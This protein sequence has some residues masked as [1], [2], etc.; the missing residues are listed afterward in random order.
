MQGVVIHIHTGVKGR[1]IQGVPKKSI[2]TP[3]IVELLDCHQTT[4][5]LFC[6]IVLF[7]ILQSQ[8][9]IWI[10][11][12]DHNIIV[13]LCLKCQRLI[14][15]QNSVLHRIGL[16]HSLSP[17]TQRRS[18]LWNTHSHLRALAVEPADC[19]KH[20]AWEFDSHMLDLGNVRI[21]QK[22]QQ[23]R[24]YYNTCMAAGFILNQCM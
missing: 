3:F 23:S 8:S 16:P 24:L 5:K 9:I 7:K 18:L 4:I 6:F 14:L 22:L 19:D 11:W 15:K 20:T 21:L 1:D 12:K 2:F 10:I 17:P 13:T